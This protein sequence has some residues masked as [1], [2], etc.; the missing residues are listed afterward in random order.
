ME[1][2][3]GEH[4]CWAMEEAFASE[5]PHA[6]RAHRGPREFQNVPGNVW[7]PL[8]LAFANMYVY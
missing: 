6:G 3:L 7:V 8:S 4:P 5:V 2:A 1:A